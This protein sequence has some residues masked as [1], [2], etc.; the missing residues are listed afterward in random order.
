M[1]K[2]FLKTTLYLICTTHDITGLSIQKISQF[3]LY[4]NTLKNSQIIIKYSLLYN[5]IKIFTKCPYIEF[6]KNNSL[7][8]ITSL[9]NNKILTIQINPQTNSIYFV[10]SK[11]PGIK[12]I[13]S[14]QVCGPFC[15]AETQ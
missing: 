11:Y 5:V 13:H 6:Q 14:P 15:T 2:I 12:L 1:N 3:Q 7:L 10:H 4:P 8:Y 9:S